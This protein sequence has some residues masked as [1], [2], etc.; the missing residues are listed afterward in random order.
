[1][2]DL[3]IMLDEIGERA[4]SG[5]WIDRLIESQ[6]LHMIGPLAEWLEE[7][8][9]ADEAETCL[10]RAM[11]TGE[12]TIASFLSDLLHENCEALLRLRCGVSSSRHD[13]YRE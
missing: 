13:G 11:S 3:V 6:Q 2:L 7:N 12:L 1:M 8:G 9:G 10:R 5:E 4:E